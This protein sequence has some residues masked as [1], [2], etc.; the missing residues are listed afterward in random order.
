MDAFFAS[1]ELLRYPQ[2]QG[3]P[4][5]IGGERHTPEHEARLLQRWGAL[6]RIPL[7]AFARLASYAGRGVITT[8]TYAARQ[9]GIGSGMGIMKAARLCPQ[10]ILL[11]IDFARYRHY[12]RLFKDIILTHVPAIED[13]GLDEVYIDFTHI[14]G[15]Q[16]GGGLPLAQRIQHAIHTATGLTCSIG[17]APNKLLAKIGSE[18]HKPHG[19]T[20]LYPEDLAPRIWPLPCRKINGIGPKTDARL[21]RLHIHTIG[22]LANCPL[23]RLIK[24]FGPTLGHWL[25]QT[26]HGHDNR[27]LDTGSPPITISRETTFARD[28]H[29]THDKT[30]LSAH[31]TRLCER[32][33]DD[34]RQKGYAGRT[35]TIKVKFADFRSVT[36]AITISD[37]TQDAAT[38]LRIARQCLRRI[39]LPP[40]IRLL[41]I[42]IS[43]L[44][45]WHTPNITPAQAS[46]PPTPHHPLSH[47][48]R[49][50]LLT[51]P[52]F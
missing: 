13:R 5:V 2:L 25:H 6:N 29:I 42:S 3:Q 1:V 36:R 38:I 19:I 40:H 20:I 35:I 32:T 27:P 22:E 33:T 10:A 7:T 50:D 46:H 12:S 48:V 45:P 28:L 8:A 26:A 14:P 24:H 39:A 52:L 11:P 15:G 16:D 30:E 21:Q 9:Y 4:V 47:T 51:L 49:H 37:H 17:I 34:L 23:P 31:L 44:T 41:G 43:K 18:F